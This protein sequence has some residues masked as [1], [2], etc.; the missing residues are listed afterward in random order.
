MCRIPRRRF[1]GSCRHGQNP[2]GRI[3]PTADGST[4]TDSST[5]LIPSWAQRII[6]G[7][8]FAL[9]AQ[10]HV[11]AAQRLHENW[12]MPLLSASTRASSV[13][14]APARDA[15]ISRRPG[16]CEN[17]APERSVDAPRTPSAAPRSATVRRRG[18]QAPPV[19]RPGS[20]WP[21]RRA[22]SGCSR[23]KRGTP[24]KRL[25]RGRV[26]LDMKYLDVK[27]LAR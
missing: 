16:I 18:A 8:D 3:S 9:L 4:A 6:N 12:A 25:Y 20:S 19:T 17:G 7:D 23:A 10:V 14:A 27:I 21:P 5:R 24:A 26:W 22:T 11:V 13:R 2:S 15:R 1:R